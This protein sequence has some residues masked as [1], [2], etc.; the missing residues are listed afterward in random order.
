VQPSYITKATS[1]SEYI[2]LQKG[3]T[4]Q[5]E[6]SKQNQKKCLYISHNNAIVRNKELT[7]IAELVNDEAYKNLY[8]ESDYTK[9]G[10]MVFLDFGFILMYVKHLSKY[11]IEPKDIIYSLEKVKDYTFDDYKNYITDCLNNNQFINVAEIKLMELAGESA[12]YIKTLTD[13]RQKV[14]D[15][16]E[17]KHQEQEENRKQEDQAYVTEQNK[18]AED[19]INTAEHAIIN[20]QNVK[21]IDITVYKSRYESNTTSLILSLIKK[22]DINVPLKVQGWINKALANIIYDAEYD[23]YSYQYY[24]SSADSKV[25]SRYLYQL[26][27][28]IKEKYGTITEAS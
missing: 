28:K 18:K 19:I 10:G 21:N 2:E 16:R 7:C 15:M 1:Y 25:F 12:D 27:C 22:Y 6:Q 23:D 8:V 17:Q 24:K 3:L 5:K 26:I 13:H 14:I 11:D 9:D 4:E 20:H